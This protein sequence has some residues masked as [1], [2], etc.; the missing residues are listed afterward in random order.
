MTA[1][2][3]F[4]KRP[5]LPLRMDSFCAKAFAEAME[6]IPVTLAENAGLHPMQ[7]VTELRNKHSAGETSAGINIRMVRNILESI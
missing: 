1:A 6:I 7:I 5:S 4:L 2:T 3:W